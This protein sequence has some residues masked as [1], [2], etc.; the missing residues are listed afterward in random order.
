MRTRE[1]TF[2][3]YRFYPKFSVYTWCSLAILYSYWSE[4]YSALYLIG[5]LIDLTS[6][7]ITTNWYLKI[8]LRFEVFLSCDSFTRKNWK[9]FKERK[10]EELY[11]HVWGFLA[12]NNL[13][14]KY[15]RVERLNTRDF[16]RES[17]YNNM[18]INAT[19]F[20]V[21]RRLKVLKAERSFISIY[22][23]MRSD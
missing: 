4:N 16:G 6:K 9:T 2:K 17:N 13:P 7:I 20:G 18:T 21:S 5:I 22:D 3:N 15:F 14:K 19:S 1:V 12:S 23:M 11:S 8:L 10:V